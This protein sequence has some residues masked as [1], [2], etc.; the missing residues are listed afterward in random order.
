MDGLF[1]GFKLPVSLHLWSPYRQRTSRTEG[2]FVLPKQE[3]LRNREWGFSLR[4]GLLKESPPCLYPVSRFSP[5][6]TQF[7]PLEA[8]WLVNTS[9]WSLNLKLA[10][11]TWRTNL[12][13]SLSLAIAHIMTHMY[14][15]FQK[16]KRDPDRCQHFSP[17]TVTERLTAPVRSGQRGQR[18]QLG[19]SPR[20]NHTKQQSVYIRH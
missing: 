8:A 12:V 15:D 1:S 2:G 17:R 9:G 14:R 18:W 7:S 6:F 5:D 19:R 16:A 13:I 20:R 11:R 3:P 10:A 4:D